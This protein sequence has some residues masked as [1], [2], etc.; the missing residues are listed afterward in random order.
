MANVNNLPPRMPV[1]SPQ[2]LISRDAKI[3]RYR[4]SL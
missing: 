1:N 4:T 2:I 3:P